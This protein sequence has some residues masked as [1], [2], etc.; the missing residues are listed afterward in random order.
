MPSSKAVRNDA[1]NIQT[2]DIK[3]VVVIGAGI[4]G[5]GIAA[6][7]SNTGIKV[8]LL[9]IVPKDATDRDVIAKSAITRMK[10]A[11]PATD[12]MSA[13]FM[14]P[15]NAKLVTPGN[16]EDHLESA[17]KDADWIIE[18]VL[19]DLTIK[20]NLFKKIDQ[21][22]KPGAI[23]SSNTSSIP[24]KNMSEGLSEEFKKNF[25]ITHFFNPPRFMRLLELVGGEQTSPEVMETLRDFC[26]KELGKNVVECKDTP[27]FI[28]NRIGTYF[29][30]RAIIE[31]I[32]N[33]LKIEEADAV[34]GA[35]MGMPKT[36]VFGL[37]DM[38]GI[39]L[40]PH[41]TKSLLD[42]LPKSDAFHRDCSV[43]PPII[44]Q[45]I[46]EGRT[47]RRSGKGGFYNMQ[48]N[49]DGSKTKKAVDL[50]IGKYRDADRPRLKSVKAAKKNGPRAVFEGRERASD[51]AWTVM[52]DTLLYT[53][54]LVP[55]ISDEI[56][57]ID[58]AMREGYNWKYGPFELL[59]KIGIEWFT[60]KL[61]KEGRP[62]PPVLK[63]ARGRPFYRK[64]NGKMQHLTFHH[65]KQF[66][67][68]KDVPKQNGVLKLSDVKL[69]SKPILSGQS[70]SLWDIGDGVVCLEFHSLMNTIDGSILNEM[71]EA[72]KKV[73]NSNGKY[74]AMVIHNEAPN[75]S[76]GANLALAQAFV[77]AGMWDTV[78][79]MVY[80]GQAVYKALR[81]SPFPV[82]GAPNGMALGGGCEV[83]LHCD[84]VQAGAES[85]IGLVESGVGLI[86]G[87]NGCAR[88][89]ERAQ[90]AQEKPGARKGPFLSAKT[91][92]QALMMP[93]FSISTSAQ[94]ARKKLWLNPDDGISMNTDRLLTDAKAKAVSLIEG[95]KPPEPAVFQLPGESGKATLR[96]AIDDFYANGSATWHDVV[97]SEALATVLTGGDTHIGKTLTENDIQ[98]LERENFMSLLKTRQTQKRVGHMI[99]K[100][101]PLREK[102]LTEPKT[103]DELRA[104]RDEITLPRRN[105]DGKPVHGEDGRKLCA[106]S[107]ATKLFYK[108]LPFLK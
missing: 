97:V 96:M 92:F 85:Y 4:M 94:D 54:S 7:L 62:I 2:R 11:N 30:F 95:Y 105:P 35:P 88:Y 52:R 79:S 44:N 22:K 78:E 59:D 32:D 38:V 43:I 49:K 68:Y 81:E 18:V 72:I 50:Y 57:E 80:S 19:E 66:G 69:N 82:V 89:L 107:A 58:A 34:L 37:V 73:S 36:G 84:A 71:N 8:D 53:A 41:L 40:I 33:G 29:L 42:S 108:A 46:E 17:L 106:L 86:P 31:A 20:R 64:E 28:A 76:A 67:V 93:Q 56:T 10:K 5:S 77:K 6:H 24:L 14:D 65:G 87:W 9:D 26:D 103:L 25:A 83:L 12:P 74:K 75:F 55:E 23:V 21:F 99:A 70:A 15:A 61:E 27:G 63:M 51:Y 39:G 101:K 16:T 48:K 100:G 45:M 3:K 102:P 91:A 13:G 1:D 60:N 90:K 98:Q 104:M 47:G